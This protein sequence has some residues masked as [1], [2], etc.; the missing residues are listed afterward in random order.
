MMSDVSSHLHSNGAVSN[1]TSGP[2]PDSDCNEN[3]RELT[4]GFEDNFV[5]LWGQT[6]VVKRDSNRNVVGGNSSILE[7]ANNEFAFSLEEEE[8]DPIFR[9]VSGKL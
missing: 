1:Q 9:T 4:H 2:W 5:E 3:I 7:W 8:E 6:R